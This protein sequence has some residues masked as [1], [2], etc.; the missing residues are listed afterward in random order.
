MERF[1]IKMLRFGNSFGDN[2]PVLLLESGKSMHERFIGNCLPGS[3]GFT[4]DY[5]VLMNKTSS[6]DDVKWSKVVR[7]L[8]PHI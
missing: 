5:C 6:M 2:G 4:E 8:T 3:Y 1:L 7:D